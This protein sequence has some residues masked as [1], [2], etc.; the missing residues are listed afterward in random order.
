MAKSKKAT[1]LGIIGNPLASAEQRAAAEL[2][3]AKL[4][5]SASFESER[6]V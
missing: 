6:P 4:T 2:E 1:L 3:L 5:A